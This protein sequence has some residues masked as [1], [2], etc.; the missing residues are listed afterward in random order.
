MYEVLNSRQQ[1]AK[2]INNSF[3]G[4]LDSSLP[5]ALEI[6]AEAVTAFG[7]QSI[8]HTKAYLEDHG[9][10]VRLAD[11]DSCGVEL[12]ATMSTE[13]VEIW[14][15]RIVQE[16]SS[17][18]FQNKL[19]LQYEKQLRPC[20]VFQK[21]MY[22]GYNPCTKTLLNKGVKAKRR[23]ITPYAR[24]TF[25]SVIDLLC[26]VGDAE[27]AYEYIKARF[28]FLE[29]IAARPWKLTEN[30]GVEVNI[31]EFAVSCAIKHSSEYKSTPSLGYRVNQKLPLPLGPAERISYLY[32]Y[33][34]KDH[35]HTTGKEIA[36]IDK[37][38]PIEIMKQ[39]EEWS[40]DAVKV[41]QEHQ[42]EL[43]QYFS[44]VS[45]TL[46]SRLDCLYNE[47]LTRIKTKQGIIGSIRDC[48]VV[49][50]NKPARTG[51]ISE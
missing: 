42:L 9:Y 31:D 19:I 11:T 37:A 5:F 2:T 27:A 23:N 49:F 51:T 44:V 15:T 12:P 45:A 28:K 20:L 34:E 4:L 16:I 25:T 10:P 7:R 22:V 17:T 6:I 3:Y 32:Y 8:Q 50:L 46:S 33:D 24:Q 41:L 38:T 40:I 47:T 21:K 43:L 35:K 14:G 36:N 29:T 1:A 30:G 26:R 39:H 48:R 13:D 18:L